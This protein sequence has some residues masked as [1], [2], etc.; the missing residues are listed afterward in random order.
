MREDSIVIVASV[1][2]DMD[3]EESE[4]QVMRPTI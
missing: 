4:S 3:P 2:F 1:S